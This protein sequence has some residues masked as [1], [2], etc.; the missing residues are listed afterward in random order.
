LSATANIGLQSL[1]IENFRNIKRA[2]L[3]FSP[4]INLITGFNAAGKTSLLEAIYCLGRVRS[5]RALN[6]NQLVREGES[7]YR[8]VGRIG[9][10]SGRSIPIGMERHRGNY[11]IHLEGQ[12]VQRLSDLA[13]R[14]PVQ[15]MTSDTANILNGGPGYRRQSLDWALFHVEQGYRL[16]WQRYSRVLRQRNAALR[17]HAPPAQIMTWDRE[18][19]EAADSLD[20]LRRNYIAELEPYIQNELENLLPGVLLS[21]RYSSGWPRDVS[22][23]AALKSNLD[24]DL[25]QGYTHCGPH[26]AD[27]VLMVDSKPVQNSFSRGQQKALIVAFLMGQV[28]FQHALDAPRGAL[29]LDDL[30]SELDEAHQ[31]RILLCLK[32]IGTQAFVT[33]IN[34]QTAKLAEWPGMK[35]FHVEHGVVREVL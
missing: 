23:E 1:D 9:L 5:F 3:L 6:A 24:K 18:L 32:E 7:S 25:A 12:P 8:L 16:L 13:G 20:R 31:S 15:I 19:T 22:L 30:G 28:K 27:M 34:S 21:L 10:S 17:A 2:S 33:A 26:R 29:L 14:F 35:R 4:S 11:R